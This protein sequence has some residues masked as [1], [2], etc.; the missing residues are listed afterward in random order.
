[1]YSVGA[2]VA[3]FAEQYAQVFEAGFLNPDSS[4]PGGA[5]GDLLL[6]IH[7]VVLGRKLPEKAAA[8][9]RR[10]WWLR[11]IPIQDPEHPYTV[12]SK[13]KEEMNWCG[14][15]ATYVLIN[16]GF[17]VKWNR[18]IVSLSPYELTHLY[19]GPGK[20]LPAPRVGDIAVSK[21]SGQHYMIIVGP[22]DS[23]SGEPPK[24]FRTVEGNMGNPHPVRH[25]THM[26]ADFGELYQVVE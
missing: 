22:P 26:M 5:A 13:T 10:G 21:G 4:K 25:F 20:P 12:K 7:E 16:A 19:P 24:V 6:D 17:Q 1:M 23:P 8:D 15:F 9:L 3:R 14:M 18:A 2:R 11:K